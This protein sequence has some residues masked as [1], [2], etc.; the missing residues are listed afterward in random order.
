MGES[1]RSDLVGRRLRL[2]VNRASVTYHQDQNEYFF[3]LF[4]RVGPAQQ[5]EIVCESANLTP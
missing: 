3:V 1:H 2:I 5:A 4:C